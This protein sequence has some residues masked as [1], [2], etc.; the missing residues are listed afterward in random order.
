MPPDPWAFGWTQLLTI[1]GFIV[2]V[3]LAIQGFNTFEQWR[4][5]R[6]EEIRITTAAEFLSI[7]YQSKNV[8]EMIRCPLIES[9]EWGDL[10]KRSD[11]SESDKD[12]IRTSHAVYKRIHANKD[13]FDRLWRCQPQAMAFFGPHVEAVFNLIHKARRHIEVAC[14]MLADP[15]A[16]DPTQSDDTRELYIQLRCDVFDYSKSQPEL[17]RVGKMLKDFVA[18]TEAICLPVIQRPF[19]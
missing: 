1:V 3:G 17:D 6:L 16:T 5:Q 12:R 8:F 19:R 18:Q 11:I 2:T 14:D 9:F 4:R 13:F 7:A 15:L 10:D